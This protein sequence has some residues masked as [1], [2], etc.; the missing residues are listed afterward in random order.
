MK[1]LRFL[2]NILAR[3]ASSQH[4]SPSTA[5]SAVNPPRRIGVIDKDSNKISYPDTRQ[6]N[7]SGENMKK[8]IAAMILTMPLIAVPAFADDAK[9][10]AQ[11]LGTCAH[12][13]GDKKGDDREAFIKDCKQKKMD[14]R[15]VQNEKMK[16]CN[17][18][19]ASK[20]GD[21]RKAFMKECLSK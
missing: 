7:P 16:T 6:S 11:K 14:G 2:T 21:E 8:L 18:S 4:C 1:S 19:A 3:E 10:K 5:F 17:A 15:K 9:P 13:A 12:Q 20:T